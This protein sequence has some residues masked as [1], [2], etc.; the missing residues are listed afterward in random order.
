[1][2]GAAL[3]LALMRLLMFLQFVLRL[4]DFPALL[5]AELLLAC[6]LLW[7]CDYLLWFLLDFQT[8]PHLHG[9]CH[10]AGGAAA[11]FGASAV[12][13]NKYQLVRARSYSD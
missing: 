9:S 13:R 2:R 11:L 7:H 4:H 5:T 6:G 1:M 12:A 8:I 10:C 3:L